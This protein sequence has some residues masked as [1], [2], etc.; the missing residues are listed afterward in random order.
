MFSGNYHIL[1]IYGLENLRMG[2]LDFKDSYSDFSH[3]F[4]RL[5]SIDEGNKWELL[6]P[7]IFGGQC[8]VHIK[9]HMPTPQSNTSV[10]SIQLR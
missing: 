6:N 4:I 10:F 9:L 2:N 3:P 5:M 7:L 1:P 8:S